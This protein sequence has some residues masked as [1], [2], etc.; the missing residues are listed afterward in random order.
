MWFILTPSFL[1]SHYQ[2]GG[3]EIIL[4]SSCSYFSFIQH[5]TFIYEIP[6]CAE[7][8]SYTPTGQRRKEFL[9]CKMYKISSFN[10]SKLCQPEL[11]IC[12]LWQLLNFL[13][14]LIKL[15][16][17]P[18]LSASPVGLP[19]SLS[20]PPKASTEAGRSLYQKGKLLEFRQL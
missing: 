1:P 2:W 10:L 3:G 19:L 18:T 4:H 11:L 9:W 17:P 20:L 5:E 12:S 6:T 16:T 15:Y 7:H 8:W 13:P 14:P